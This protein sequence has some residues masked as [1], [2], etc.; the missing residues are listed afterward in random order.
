M[1][2]KI[3]IKM[4]LIEVEYEGS[5][6][7]IKTEL[8]GMVEA[9]CDLHKATVLLA[10]S[11]DTTSASQLGIESLPPKAPPLKLSSSSIA[12]KLECKTGSDLVLAASAYLTLVEQSESFE[13]AQLLNTMKIATGYY[14]SSYSNNLSGYL[15]RLVAEGRLLQEATGRY[16]LSSSAK[17]ELEQ[18]LA[19]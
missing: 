9:V 1:S 18:Q 11:H 15:Q 16:A 14:K 19:S 6:E 17:R 13:R 7:F 8:L 4:G 2:G 10:G 12:A 5:E 3:R